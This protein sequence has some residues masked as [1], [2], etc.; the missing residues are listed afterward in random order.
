MFTVYDHRSTAGRSCLNTPLESR[1]GKPIQVFGSRNYLIFLLSLSTTNINLSK[2]LLIAHRILEK[3]V[4]KT[5]NVFTFSFLST[6]SINTNYK[7]I[8]P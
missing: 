2:T 8:T 7:H 1:M 3:N 5:L 4:C 6:F